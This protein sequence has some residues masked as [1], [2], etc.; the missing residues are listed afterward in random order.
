MRGHPPPIPKLHLCENLVVRGWGTREVG[1]HLW[2][3]FPPTRL[4]HLHPAPFAPWTKVC[5]WGGVR[6]P[7]G[8]H[9]FKDPG[10]AGLGL[11]IWADNAPLGRPWLNLSRVGLAKT[12]QLPQNGLQSTLLKKKHPQPQKTFPKSPQHTIFGHF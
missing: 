9:L 4:F 10:V 3:G 7:Q 12:G 2:G 6:L 8:T 5:Q 1:T 11:E